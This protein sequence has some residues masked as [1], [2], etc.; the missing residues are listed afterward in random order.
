M[1]TMHVVFAPLCI[2]IFPSIYLIRYN[3]NNKTSFLCK[4]R[5]THNHRKDCCNTS[6]NYFTATLADR[7]SNWMRSGVYLPWDSMMT[8]Q[9]RCMGPLGAPLRGVGAVTCLIFSNTEII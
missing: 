7:E 6:V 4:F 3:N 5:R 1:T 8:L 2:R 9:A